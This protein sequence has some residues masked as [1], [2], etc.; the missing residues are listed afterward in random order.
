MAVSIV[1]YSKITQEACNFVWKSDLIYNCPD[2][3]CFVLFSLHVIFIRD[4]TDYIF[5]HETLPGDDL[6]LT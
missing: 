5:V 1:D 6:L 4:E 2:S 3:S